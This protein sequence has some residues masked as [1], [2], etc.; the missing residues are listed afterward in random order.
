MDVEIPTEASFPDV[1]E[2]PSFVQTSPSVRPSAPPAQIPSW[3]TQEDRLKDQQQQQLLQEQQRLQEQIR[4]LEQQ[5][6]QEQQRAQEQ[7][8]LQALELKKQQLQQQQLLQQMQSQQKP[9]TPAPRPTNGAAGTGAIPPSSLLNSKAR[10]LLQEQEWKPTY[11]P[12]DFIPEEDAIIDATQ[13]AKYVLSALQFDDVP[14]AIKYLCH[15]LVK[16]TGEEDLFS[17]K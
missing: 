11:Q 15:C 4:M 9:A 6:L 13:H 17:P 1:P 2:I 7:Q 10:Q 14:T 8:R 3:P 12:G 16:L 5:R